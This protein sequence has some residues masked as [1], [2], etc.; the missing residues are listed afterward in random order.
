MTK[1]TAF[2]MLSAIAFFTQSFKPA[3]T[4]QQ[5]INAQIGG[6]S[7]V[8]NTSNN[9]T[10]QLTGGKTAVLSFDGA[11][12]T[13]KINVAYK[14]NEVGDI[15]V[16]GISYELDGKKF[17]N[18]PEATSMNVSKFEWSSD[19]KSFV[20]SAA[21]DCKAQSEGAF[22]PNDDAIAIQGNIQDVVVKVSSLDMATINE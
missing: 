6:Q 8:L 14:I 5:P 4:V 20:L 3:E 1:S 15:L 16:K 19:K 12:P 2:V 22:Q 9:Y 17:Q 21:F 7:F 11:T 13:Q 10:A 18:I